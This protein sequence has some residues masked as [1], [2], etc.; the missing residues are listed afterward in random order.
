M[1]TAIQ[2]V[3][4]MITQRGY[5]ITKSDDDIIVGTNSTGEHIIVFTQS[6]AKLNID[7]VKEYIS[8]LHKMEMKHCIVI[9]VEN[10]TSI[11]KKLIENSVDI[12]IEIFTLEELQYNITK[13]RLV[14]KHIILSPTESKE[15][16]QLYGL[17]YPVILRT[18]PIARFYDFNR[19]D[20][21]KIIRMNGVDEYIT[22]RIVK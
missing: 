5:K 1:D 3:T 4:E 2:T 12:K 16:K 19:G 7:R 13:H 9:Y 15:F 17:K 14:P 22:Y 20:V 10:V 21:I 8:I 11:T 6:V 18:D